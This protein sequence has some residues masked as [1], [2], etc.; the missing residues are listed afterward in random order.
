[1]GALC[2]P[3][4]HPLN[5]NIIITKKEHM[6]EKPLTVETRFDKIKTEQMFDDRS[7]GYG[8]SREYVASA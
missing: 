6:F 2:P 5:G 7:V 8:Y 4:C 3:P 1:M